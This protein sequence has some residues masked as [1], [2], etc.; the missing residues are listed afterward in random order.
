MKFKLP[1]AGF[2]VCLASVSA[3][4]CFEPLYLANYLIEFLRRCQTTG[5]NQRRCTA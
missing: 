5:V 4:S 1:I 2:L 3:Y